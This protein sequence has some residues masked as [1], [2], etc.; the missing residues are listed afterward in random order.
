MSLPWFWLPDEVMRWCERRFVPAGETKC[1][2]ASPPRR[3]WFFSVDLRLVLTT[4]AR[5]VSLGR[6][7][8]SD[9]V[10]AARTFHR[11]ALGPSGSSVRQSSAARRC[12]S[13]ASA[14]SASQLQFDWLR[15]EMLKRRRIQPPRGLDW[16]SLRDDFGRARSVTLS[17]TGCGRSQLAP[18]PAGRSTHALGPDVTAICLNRDC[19][20]FGF[21]SPAER[22]TESHILLL[23]VDHPDHRHSIPVGP[24]CSRKSIACRR[25]ARHISRPDVEDHHA[26]VAVGRGFSA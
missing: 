9:V 10:S 5:A 17:G 1:W 26:A 2:P 15:A 3:S 16:T 14:W 24:A 13:S 8:L 12:A 6:A 11:R 21:A 25:Q 19:R 4:R 23:I 22:W 18:M 20:Q 7:W